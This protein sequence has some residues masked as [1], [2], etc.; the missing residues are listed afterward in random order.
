MTETPPPYKPCGHD[1]TPYVE[2]RT[3]PAT[4]GTIQVAEIMLD[5]IQACAQVLYDYADVK[6]AKVI[7]RFVNGRLQLDHMRL[8]DGTCI[9]FPP[10]PDSVP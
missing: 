8:P 9:P 4:G 6:G 10:R 3:G 1:G 2:P 5:Y 7:E